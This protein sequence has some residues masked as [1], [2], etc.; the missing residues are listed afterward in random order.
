MLETK[1]CPQTVFRSSTMVMVMEN[2]IC[3]TEVKEMEDLRLRL[4]V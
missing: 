1:I 4:H 3:K 2:R